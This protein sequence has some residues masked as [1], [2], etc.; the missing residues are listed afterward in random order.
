MARKKKPE[1]HVN[2]ERWLVSYADFITLLFAFFVVMYALSSVN[3]GK[4]R[5]L[6]DSMIAAFR[7][8]PQSLRPIQIGEA[9]KA[10]PKIVPDSM[11]NMK[12]IPPSKQPIEESDVEK[13]KQDKEAG[14]RDRQKLND[15]QKKLEKSLGG[16][17]ENDLISVKRTS[18]GL[19][20][21][22]NSSILFDSGRASIQAKAVP[23]LTDVADSIKDLPNA[24][25]VEGFT[26]NIPI[27]TTAFPSNWELSAGR[28]ASVV[29]IFSD[30]G[31]DPFRLAAV[32][33]GEYR[34]IA[35]NTTAEGRKSNRR[36]VI[37]IL[38][39]AAAKLYDLEQVVELRPDGVREKNIDLDTPPELI[40]MPVMTPTVPVP[41]GFPEDL[42]LRGRGNNTSEPE[43]QGRQL[44]IIE[45]LD[46]VGIE[47]QDR[48]P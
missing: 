3:E 23:V 35:L 32:G 37:V 26:D 15:V 9:V 25:R 30:E 43:A 48:A 17:I 4:Y 45:T 20:I 8:A 47:S 42:P 29:H 28:A 38:N 1:E 2:H 16:M 19:E 36:V 34:P 12:P 44:T 40:E 7:N 13:Q 18:Q 39:E 41:D 6:S 5:V 46:E 21:E 24:I 31:V 27:E 10:P 14:M 33:Y 22:I 11:R